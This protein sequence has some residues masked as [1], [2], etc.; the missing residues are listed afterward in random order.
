MTKTETLI[1]RCK[2]LGIDT[3]SL[4]NNEQRQAAIDTVE[5][6]LKGASDDKAE[7]DKVAAEEKAAADKV[8][9]DKVAAEE[10][11]AADKAE[12]D[13][14]AASKKAPAKKAKELVYKDDRGVKWVFKKNAPKSLRIDGHPMSQ[15]EI[16]NTEEVI[17]ELVLGNNS[18][19]TQ[20]QN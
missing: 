11:A 14:V 6:E 19:L 9:A 10:K 16:I 2:E 15:E 17:S 5:A 12:A 4:T 13:K 18:F 3:E 7:A 8:E 20:K 1:E